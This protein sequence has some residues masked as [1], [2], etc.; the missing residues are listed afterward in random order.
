MPMNALKK[1]DVIPE[2][3]AQDL[4]DPVN[5]RINRNSESF[6]PTSRNES[7][8]GLFRWVPLSIFG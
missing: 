4:L 8:A 6:E 3:I 5:L 1:E 7:E 2:E